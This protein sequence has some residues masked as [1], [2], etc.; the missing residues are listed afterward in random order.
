MQIVC[1]EIYK[2]PVL[3]AALAKSQRT[4]RNFASLSAKV[5][6]DFC[7]GGTEKLFTIQM[8]FWTHAVFDRE[9]WRRTGKGIS[10]EYPWSVRLR[11][12]TGESVWVL[13]SLSVG[14]ESCCHVY[15]SPILVEKT[16]VL[17]IKLWITR[18]YPVSK[19]RSRKLWIM[20]IT[21]WINW[22]LTSI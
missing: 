10:Q 14:V 9:L 4:V 16:R 20:W 8:T 5:A 13:T 17:W 18:G 22:G 15:K 11:A 1:T 6:R 2:N 12:E 7:K 21:L 19:W 3:C